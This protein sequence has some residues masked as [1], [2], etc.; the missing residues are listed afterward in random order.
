M[1]NNKIKRNISLTKTKN[2][3]QQLV[4]AVNQLS[5]QL[6]GLFKAVDVIAETLEEKGVVTIEELQKK[7]N[8]PDPAPA[9]A[10]VPTEP[11]E[12]AEEAVS[13]DVPV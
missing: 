12:T 3:T 8:P 6:N 9:P 4:S 13:D 2:L 1:S 11:Q 7:L 10:E 5:Q